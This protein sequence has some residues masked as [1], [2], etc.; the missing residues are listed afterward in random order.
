MAEY[1]SSMY[2][3]KKIY[4]NTMNDKIKNKIVIITVKLN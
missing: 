4:I 1:T 3:T 2:R